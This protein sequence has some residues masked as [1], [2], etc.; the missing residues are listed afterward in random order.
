MLTE[1]FWLIEW[2]NVNIFFSEEFFFEQKRKKPKSNF[3]ITFS[4]SMGV[5]YP[6]GLKVKV[7]VLTCIFPEIGE[8]IKKNFVSR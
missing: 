4:Y 2:V 3:L 7:G 8:V 1:K 6:C 5:G